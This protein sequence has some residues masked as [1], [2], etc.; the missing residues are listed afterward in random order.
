MAVATFSVSHHFCSFL[1]KR[2]RIGTK[3]SWVITNF[4]P[5]ITR[6]N[7]LRFSLTDSS[8]SSSPPSPESSPPTAESCVNLGL[9]SSPKAGWVRLPPSN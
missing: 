4:P 7:R 5:S 8:S 3:P 1:V 6:T 9:S 2:S